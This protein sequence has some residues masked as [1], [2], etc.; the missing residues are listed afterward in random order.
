MKAADLSE[1]CQPIYETTGH[2]IPE[3]RNL[4]TVQR[5]VLLISDLP[6]NFIVIIIT[7]IVVLIY[8]WSRW[9]LKADSH[10]ACRAHDVP[11]P[12]RAVKRL[13]CFFPI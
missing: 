11:L 1:T 3:D 9:T 2:H 6:F 4:L 12:C 10:I 5:R 8:I 7:T 13:E